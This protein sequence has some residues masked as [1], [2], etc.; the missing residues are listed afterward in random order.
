MFAVAA[1]IGALALA[2]AAVAANA[3]VAM[4]GVQFVPATVNVNVGDAVTWTNEDGIAH[5]AQADDGS[6]DTGIFSTG[7]RSVTL[8]QPGTFGYFCAV[9][10]TTMR[11]TVNVA[12]AATPPPTPAP[13][14]PPA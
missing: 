14:P 12:A 3:G 4:R 5:S 13:T 2:N 7:S 11:G 1:L 10:P 6:F 8:T 9:H